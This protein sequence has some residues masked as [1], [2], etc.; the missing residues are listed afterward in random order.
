MSKSSSYRNKYRPSKEFN[1]R[2]VYEMDE[3][4][5]TIMIKKRGVI[6][7]ARSLPLQR[8]I[9]DPAKICAY[10]HIRKEGNEDPPSVPIF[11]KDIKVNQ[12]FGDNQPGPS[13]ESRASVEKS[14][15]RSK[16]RD[17]RYRSRT[18]ERTAEA[19][20]NLEEPT[21]QRVVVGIEVE[22][23][24][25]DID[26]IP[27]EG[28]MFRRDDRDL[29]NIVR[30]ILTYGRGNQESPEAEVLG[31]L[32]RLEKTPE[33][34]VLETH[35][36]ESPEPEAEVLGILSEMSKAAQKVIPEADNGSR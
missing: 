21:G 24:G 20:K 31:V 2:R 10:V 4:G 5:L 27:Q 12:N 30:G 28:D 35:I 15:S 19:G 23:E 13:G 32:E 18:K 3:L 25:Q 33:A 1:N 7:A 22:E 36:E 16:H 11:G 9:D 14:R 34:K 6:A 17:N 26:Q 29:E 8:D